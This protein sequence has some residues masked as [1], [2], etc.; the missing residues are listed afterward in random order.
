MYSIGKVAE[1][2]NIST[3]ALRFYDKQ[4]L[5]PFE[6]RDAAGRRQFREQ[7]LNLIEAI[8]C[9]KEGHVPVKDIAQFIQFCM[10]GDSSLQDRYNLVAKESDNLKMKIETLQKDYDYLQ[11][12]KWY[13]KTAVEAGTEKIHFI[14]NSNFVDPQARKDFE[15]MYKN[16][17]NRKKLV[18]F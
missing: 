18:D 11:Y 1:K 12:K 17:K 7:D 13:F 16:K 15:K 2:L 6:Q 8:A 10:A 3:S 5:L 9:F 14:E 4:G